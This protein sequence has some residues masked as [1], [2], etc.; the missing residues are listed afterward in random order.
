MFLGE[1]RH[2]VGSDLVSEV[3]VGRDAICTHH[4]GLYAAGAHKTGSHVVADDGGGNAVGHQFP[5]GEACALQ[6]WPRLVGVNMNALALL[7]GGADHAERG[8]I[9]A[10]GKSS[11]VAMGEHAAFIG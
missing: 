5:R 3:S 8:S 1:N 4:D 7:D 9:A 11:G 10:S 6:K 2:V